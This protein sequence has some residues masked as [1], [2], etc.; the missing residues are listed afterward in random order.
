M[1]SLFGEAIVHDQNTHVNRL[2]PYH[3]I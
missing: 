3:L 1:R 2:Y